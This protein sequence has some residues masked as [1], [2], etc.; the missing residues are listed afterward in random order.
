MNRRGALG[1]ILGGA[2]IPLTGASDGV[3]RGRDVEL[4][5]PAWERYVATWYCPCDLCCGTWKD[6]VL[7]QPASGLTARGHR[8]I[9]GQTVAVDPAVVPL[10]TVLEVRGHG[11]LL[12]SD[13]G[14]SVKGR[15]L[16]LFVDDHEEAVRRGRRP[17]LARPF[18]APREISPEA[19]FL[20][21]K[22]AVSR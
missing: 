10:G 3:F 6:G 15:R 13:V 21:Y 9:Q 8:P 2:A 11:L 4:P 18:I 7:V 22:R 16:D 19:G 14:R 12:A 17:L 20:V 5:P 1:L